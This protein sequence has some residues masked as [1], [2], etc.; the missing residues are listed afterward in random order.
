MPLRGKGMLVVFAEVHSRHE[1]DLNEWYNREHLDERVNLPGFH[2]ARRYVA[3][4]ARDRPKYLATYE[5]NRVGDLATPFYLQ[6]LAHPTPWSRKVTS[7]F[8]RFHRLTLRI[9]VDLAHGI[10]GFVTAIRFTPDPRKHQALAVWLESKILPRTIGRPGML[11]AFAA[12]NDPD[13]A[14]APLQASSVDRPR[15]IEAEWL[16]LLEGADASSAESAAR[17][18]FKLASLKR[19]GVTSA[20]SIGTYRLLC[21]VDAKSN[22]RR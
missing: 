5:C 22:G 14:N 8:T 11:G 1:A 21:G 9:Q 4:T 15:A 19:F 16:V 7:R 17:A 20:P 2:R 3:L 18:A 12:E 13:T 6:N 10:G